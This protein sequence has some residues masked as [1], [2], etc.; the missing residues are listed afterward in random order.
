[1][2]NILI[3]I[4]LLLFA[5][6]GFAQKS[7][8]SGTI[9]DKETGETLVGA[10]VVVIGGSQKGTIT[11][12]NGLYSFPGLEGEKAEIE[13]S[14]IGYTSQRKTVQLNGKNLFLDVALVPSKVELDQITIVEKRTDRIGDSQVEISQ[15]TLSPKAIQSIPSARNDVFRAIK[16]LPG[17]ETTE[18]M[19]PLVSVRG[20]DPGENLIMLD[21]V[22]I[23]N[24]YHFMSSSGI[25]NM[26]TVKNVDMMVG[27]FGAEYGGR[28]SSVINIATKDGNNSGVHGEVQPTTAET[29]VFLEFPVGK[30]TTMMVAGRVNYDLVGNFML[31]SNNY[32]YDANLSLTHRFNSRNRLT[33]KYFSSRDMTNLDFNYLYKYMGNTIGMG[34]EDIFDD[35]SLKWVNHWSNN[36][37]TAIWKSMITPQ[38]FMQAQAYGSFHRAN[39]FSE[40]VMNVEDV[41]FNTS[42]RFKSKVNDWSGKVS[43]DYKP[44]VWNEMKFGAEYN[45]YLFY[46]GSEVNRV[47]NAAAERTPNLISFFLEDK[48]ILGP[49]IVRP[50]VRYTSFNGADYLLEPRINAVLKLPGD[51]KIQAA[52]GKYNQSIISMNTQEFEFNQFLDYYYPLN[53]G[54]PS[55]ST[56]YILGAE[57]ALNANNMLSIDIYYKDIS[58][59]YTF[60]LLQDQYEAYALSDKVVA[61]IGKTYGVELL[62]KG[63]I[64]KFSGWASYTWSKSTRQFPHIMNGQEYDYD[65]DRR[66]SLKGVINY[67]ATKRISYS[68]AFK[69]QSGVPRSIENTLQSFYM[70]DPLTG[71][72]IYSP[73]YTVKGKNGT[74]MPWLFYLDFGLQKK[75]VSG[76]GKNLAEFFNASESYLTLNVYNALFFRRNVLYY[77]VIGG[78][79]YTYIP[80]SDNYLPTVSAGY[81]IKF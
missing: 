56:H 63:S 76:F 73:Q 15:H 4:L 49:L 61:G 32:F 57:K 11:N 17:I 18:P 16:Y 33:M 42:T 54:K 30:K 62:W 39:N 80:M 20:S 59:T 1:M 26:Q 19:S 50:G 9:T 71:Q 8:L 21:G 55:Q 53:N 43:F 38:L 24:P 74:R 2:K 37:G 41:V 79:D 67:Q 52:W 13:Y 81:T 5:S 78:S 45:K 60:D 58:R 75:V 12:E 48:L 28:N 72:M 35:M 69:A 47:E 77:L 23:Y 10:S 22:T 46:N 6:T 7:A 40:M 36:I 27:G 31:Y 64:D 44:F 3:I 68:A 65:Y 66:H 51:L 14:F 25:F 29:K 34:M 70:Y